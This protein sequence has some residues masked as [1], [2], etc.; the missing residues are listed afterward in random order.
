MKRFAILSA[1]VLALSLGRAPRAL[2]AADIGKPA[3][4]FTATDSHGQSRSLHDYRGKYVVLEWFNASCPFVKKHY[5][6]GNMQELQKIYTGK[7]VTWLSIVSSAPG[8]EG[9]LTADQANA[10]AQR[11]KAAPTA[12]LLD[13]TG[14]VGRRYEAKTTPDMFVIDPSGNLIYKGAIDDRPSTDPADIKGATNYVS[15]ALEASMAR[16]TVQVAATKSY[17]CSVKYK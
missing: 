17:G 4:D 6:S 8:A 14:A 15:A 10:V 11:W 16:R 1:A 3:P 13:P 7:G 9:F 5:N 12:I 2:A